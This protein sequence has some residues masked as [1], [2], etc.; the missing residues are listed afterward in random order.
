MARSIKE[1]KQSMTAAFMEDKTIRQK[2]G[3]TGDATF[4]DAFSAVS[5]ESLLFFIV[6]SAIWALEIIFDSFKADVNERLSTSVLATI[7]W[8]HRVCKE[9]QYGD[10]LVYDESTGQF[11]YETEDES[12]KVVKYAACRDRSGGVVILVSGEDASGNPEALASDVLSVFKKYINSRKPAGVVVDVYSYDPDTIQLSM[13]VQYDDMLTNPDGS[14]IS[15]PG[16]FPVEDAVNGYLRGIVYGGTFNKTKLID[17]VQSAEGVVDVVLNNAM[18]VSATG[19]S[20]IISGNNY[21][22]IGGAFQ[23]NNLKTGI[24]YVLQ[25]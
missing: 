22:S 1:I 25:L 8:Y 23:A 3:L 11:V 21:T 5:V 6:A 13:S 14:L 7:P 4:E 24:S 12:K 15:D 20:T 10:E 16:V 2:Y 19:V 9:F 17:A 18:A